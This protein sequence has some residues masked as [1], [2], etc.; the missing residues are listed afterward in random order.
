MVSSHHTSRTDWITAVCTLL[1]ACTGIVALA[2]AHWQ[3]KQDHDEAQVERLLGF[4]RQYDQEPLVSYRK[5]YAEKRLA[6]VTDPDSEYQLLDFF[7]TVGDLTDKGYLDVSDVW[8][9]FAGDVEPLYSDTRDMIEQQRNPTFY[10]HF[11]GLAQRMQAMEKSNG[12]DP[13]PYSK[14]ELR[15]YWQDES[16]IIAGAPALHRKRGKPASSVERPQ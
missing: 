2:Y 3:L 12:A 8:E 15:G 16:E 7:E 6:N 11:V 13:T 14:E 5:L 4:V 1:I 9:N 10:N